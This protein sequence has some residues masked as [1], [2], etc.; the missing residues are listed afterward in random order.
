MKG[1]VTRGVE[2]QCSR[3]LMILPVL[4]SLAIPVVAG[5]KSVSAKGK[6]NSKSATSK[7]SKNNASKETECQ[8]QKLVI[9]S[10]FGSRF[11]NHL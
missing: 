8:T 1:G 9:P 10:D 11:L 6:V 7:S 4:L 2:M 5:N 3:I